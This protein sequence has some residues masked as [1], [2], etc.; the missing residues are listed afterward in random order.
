MARPVLAVVDLTPRLLGYAAGLRLQERLAELRR[1]GAVPDT[2]LLVQVGARG[3]APAVARGRRRGE[4]RGAGAKAGAPG[5]GAAARLPAP[6][7]GRP[8]ASA[9]RPAADAAALPVIPC[10]PCCR[11]RQHAP[12]YTVGKRG[13][14]ADFRDG[15]E[16]QLGLRGEPPQA[17]TRAGSLHP[18]RLVCAVAALARWRAPLCGTPSPAPPCTPGPAPPCTAQAVAARGVEVAT[19][20]RGGET[21]YHGPGQLVA[22]P[23]V[24]LRGLGLGARAY[25]EGLEDAMVAA[26]GAYGVSAR[27]RVPG[28]TGVW[29]GERKLGAVG[30]RISHGV[31][32]HGLALN[33]DTDLAAFDTIV[34]CGAP[35]KAA[36]SLAA[37]V[38]APRPLGLQRPGAIVAG[39]LERLLRFGGSQP[40]ELG[41]LHSELRGFLD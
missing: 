3:V 4:A 25:V 41:Q 14:L 26:A 6:S 23:I 11:R 17:G 2:L 21:T 20:P 8:P 7:G 30:V 5:R 18:V 37:E 28:R 36:T 32:S 12:V 10:P 31:T 22:Y 29:V 39:A 15:V 33:V 1:A 38:L 40:A 27:G 16:V 13:S 24:A 9:A 34:P 35:D 19:I